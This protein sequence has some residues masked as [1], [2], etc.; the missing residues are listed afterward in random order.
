[1]YAAKHQVDVREQ[2]KTAG[3]KHGINNLLKRIFG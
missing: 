3:L 1:M 2:D